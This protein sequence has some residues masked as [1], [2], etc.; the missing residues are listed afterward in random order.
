MVILP[1][2]F[3]EYRELAEKTVYLKPYFAYGTFEEVYGHIDEIRQPKL[4]ASLV[5]Y[6]NRP[7]K[8]YSWHNIRD[9]QCRSLENLK[10]KK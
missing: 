2:I 4:R 8:P 7:F 6:R 3:G 9:L 5:E 10:R 1:T